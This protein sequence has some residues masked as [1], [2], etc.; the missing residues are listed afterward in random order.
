MDVELNKFIIR[1][2]IIQLTTNEA[3]IDFW[4]IFLPTIVQ[5]DS[6]PRT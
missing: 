6:H 2:F 4:T 1:I 3:I 5:S